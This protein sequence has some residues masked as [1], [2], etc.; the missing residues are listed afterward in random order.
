MNDTAWLQ[1]TRATTDAELQAVAAVVQEGGYTA[2]HHL[3]ESIKQQ[4]KTMQEDEVPRMLSCLDKA[5]RLFPEPGR[6]SPSWEHIWQ[7]LDRMTEIKAK[8]MQTVPVQERDGEWQVILDNPHTIQGVVCHTGLTFHEAAYLYS[9]F[10][11]G[12]ERNEYLRLQ[13]I[14][15]AVTDVGL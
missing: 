13:K 9:Y 8:L 2:F 4:I 10:R 12:L 3:L 5:G 7:E 6:F 11:P 1:L 15:T 14:Q